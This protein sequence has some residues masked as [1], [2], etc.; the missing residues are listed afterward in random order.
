MEMMIVG[1]GVPLVLIPGI[2]GR[3]E[4]M[5]PAVEALSA[6]FRVM[7]FPLCGERASRRRFE[8][9]R[10]LDNYVDQI[11]DALSACGAET[12]V[13]CG[14][15]FGGL[16]AV[17][18]AAARP[19]R[20]SALILA[21][22]PGPGFRLRPRHRVYAKAPLLFGPALLAEMP[23]R[24]GKELSSVF[25]DRRDRVRFA[26][27]QVRTFLEAP[28]S[29]SRMA[30]RAELLGAP[31]LLDDCARISSPTLVVTGEPALDYIVPVAGTS[32]YLRLIDGAQSVQIPRTG[33]LGYITRPEIFTQMVSNFVT[34]RRAP[35]VRNPHA[36]A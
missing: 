21:S 35:S 30:E 8:T 9:A 32:E 12:A 23:G 20:T 17:H 7:T 5:R 11:D 13:V 6:A 28:V 26:W 1:H 34:S 4:Y 33:H 24:V 16:I 31:Q 3:W 36:A 27:R 22:A 15:S 14:V 10:G 2:Q 18:Y 19:S 25:P 29:V